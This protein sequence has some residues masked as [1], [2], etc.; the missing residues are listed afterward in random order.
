MFTTAL[1]L[2]LCAAAP[3]DGPA[4]GGFR[5]PAGAG[6]AAC[7][8]PDALDVETNLRWKTEVPAGYS[9][10]VVAGDALFV[11]AAENKTLST[12]CL[13]RASGALR[14]RRDVEFDGKRPGAN[15]SAAPTPVTD[16]ERVYVLFHSV[17]MLAYDVAGEELWR[18][19]LGEFNIPH[20][21]SSS[22]VLH[23]DLLVQL[24]DQDTHSFLAAYDKVT[25]E[26]RWKVE[27]NGFTHSYTT[28]AIYAP[29]DGPAQVVVSGA[30]EVASYRLSDGEKLWWAGGSAWLTKALPVFAGDLCLI[31]AYSLPTT[32]L[33][34]PRLNQPWDE[35][36]AERDANGD[37]KIARD[38]WVHKMLHMVWFIFDLDGDGL[39][40]EH[41]WDYVQKSTTAT[42][43]LYAIRMGGAGNV[44][45]SHV[46]WVYDNRRGLPDCPSPL[47]LDGTLFLI[48]EGGILTTL[49]A[50]TGELGKQARVGEPDQYFASPVSA[51]GKLLLAGQSGQLCVVKADKEWELISR[52]DLGEQ[53]WSTPAIVD[54][55]VYVR[56]SK[57]LY[58]FG[59]GER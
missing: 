36:L 2:A 25:G 5:G 27:R 24:V 28:P 52:H 4:W 35:V 54:G 34:L 6:I 56:T 49:D 44:T 9:S 51:G 15:S 20:G 38:E 37:G 12:I 50:A 47:A 59:A 53:I 46:Q 32:E 7:E 22:P 13:D 21:M 43:G 45:E 1:L 41:D 55:A 8:L 42:G 30:L 33:G 23:G 57:A 40:D 19:D 10:P 48:K 16:G 18:K 39:F 3:H 26:E 58:C 31:S 11:T 14:W 17:G 29:A